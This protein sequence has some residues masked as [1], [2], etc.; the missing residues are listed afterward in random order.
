MIAPGSRP[1]WTWGQPGPWTPQRKRKSPSQW[2]R[3]QK[4]T[5]YFLDKKAAKSFASADEKDK[6]DTAEKVTVV[7]L[8][9]EINLTEIQAT[10][11]EE[12]V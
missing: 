1:P 12:E 11:Q 5:K 10:V 4:R 6:V 2:K 8:V 7:D 9:D 3:D